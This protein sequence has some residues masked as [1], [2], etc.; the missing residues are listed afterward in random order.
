MVKKNKKSRFLLALL[1]YISIFF[2][3]LIISMVIDTTYDAKKL[4]SACIAAYVIIGICLIIHIG[5]S[6]GDFFEPITFISI[7]YMMLFIFEPMIDIYEDNLNW[8]G[9]NYTS[10]GVKGT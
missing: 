4:F 2:F 6:G 7:L 8:F 1:V 5:T 10:F 9:G 3:L